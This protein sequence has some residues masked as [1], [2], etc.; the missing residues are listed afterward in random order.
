MSTTVVDPRIDEQERRRQLYGGTLFYFTPTKGSQ[1]L[2]D[3][4]WELISE[5][6]APLDPVQ[7]QEE[8]PVEKFVDFIGPMKTEF[9]HHQRSKELITEMLVELGCDPDETYFDIPR[10]RVV[11]H[12]GYL[13]SGVGYA[14]D[15]HRDIWYAAPPCQLNWW[16]PINDIGET[17]ALAFHPR[18]WT[19]P[20]EN[21][22]DGFDAY[23]WN[24]VGRAEAAKHVT[25][26]TRNHPRPTG[27]IELEPDARIVGPPAS[28]LVFSA[29]QLHSTVPNTSGK[30]R[31]S[32]DFRTVNRGDMVN[33]MGAPSVDNA[34]TGTTA[35]DFLRAS[36]YERLPD[37]VVALYDVG[38]EHE[39]P[40]VFDPGAVR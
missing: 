2:C 32:L 7:A 16:L 15:A 34:S 1:A 17:S 29:A 6:F 36:D 8:L 22:S 23:E 20:V 13:T 27:P 11:T 12:S 25:S 3:F 35:R 19:D 18:Y 4:A 39:G 28:V 24:R 30:T 5:A 37:D 21:S 38:S 33:R 40:L 31:F 14:Y 9:T 26:D 10:M